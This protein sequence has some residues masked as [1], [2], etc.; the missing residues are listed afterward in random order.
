[1]IWHLAPNGRMGMVLAN[2][3]LSSQ[4]GGEGDIRKNIIEA[5]LVECIVA[6]PSQ[7]FYTTQIP[8]SLW[9][10]ARNKKQKGKTL[11]LDARK[12][13]T[14]VTRK[15]RELTDEDIK[16]LADAYNA[17]ADGTLEEV[18]GFSAVA[19][20]QEIAEQDYILTPGRYVGIEKQEEDGEPFGEKMERLTRELSQLF[21]QSHQL[22]Q[23]I[24]EK[25]GGIGFEL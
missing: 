21:E 15:L 8:V 11:F 9:F 6:M 18:K 13:G 12:L 4:S 2:G 23:E 24:R 20:I 14:M 22:E 25:L 16:K 5:D 17:Y 3:S 1:M 19:T 7:L 10:L